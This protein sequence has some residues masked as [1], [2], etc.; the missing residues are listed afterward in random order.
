MGKEIEKKFL[1][2]NE[3]WRGLA[4]GIHYCQGYLSTEKDRTAGRSVGTGVD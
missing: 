4:E 1:I 2:T 3:D